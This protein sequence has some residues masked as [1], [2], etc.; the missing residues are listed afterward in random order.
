MSDLSDVEYADRLSRR[1]A[2]ML[3]FLAIVFL[4]GQAIYFSGPE[5]PTRTV[6]QVKVSAWLVWAVVL[7]FLLASGGGLF[8]GRKVRALMDDESTIAN[9]HRAYSMG[10]W[11]AVGA[12]V[13]LYVVTMFESVSGRE[14]IHIILT[15]AVAGALLMFGMLERRAHRERAEP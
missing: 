14:A 7:L 9:R 13:G 2:R 1:R 6:D 12:A 11:T 15:M 5:M 3:P 10:F 8:R 4:A